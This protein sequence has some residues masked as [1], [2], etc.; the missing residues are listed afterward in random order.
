M[1]VSSVHWPAS[2]PNGPPPC[3]SVN[4]LKL[5]RGQNST[6]AP[7]A[8]PVASPR[9]QPRNRFEIESS[10]FTKSV[11]RHLRSPV[12]LT[13]SV[14]VTPGSEERSC[15]LLV[16][17]TKELLKAR[18][19]L[20]LVYRIELVAQFV[21]RPR[22][23]DEILAGVAGRSDV[24]SAFA[25]RH[26]V[27]PSRGHLA[28][29]ECASFVHTVRPKFLLKDIHSCRR[30]KVSNPWLVSSTSSPPV[31]DAEFRMQNAKWFS[32]SARSALCALHSSFKC[33]ALELLRVQ[34]FKN[35]YARLVTLQI[36]A[37]I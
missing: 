31:L 7:T 5:P 25:A 6:A 23:V 21:M 19:G 26:N 29:T 17:P 14:A 1:D 3:M 13:R 22:F 35:W 8:S 20:D 11:Q 2:R 34:G 30:L 32:V 4:G 18:I 36:Q 28:V 10:A 16:E 9:R 33:G 24:S 27:V 37:L 15:L 12:C